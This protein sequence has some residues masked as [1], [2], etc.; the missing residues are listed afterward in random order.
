[1]ESVACFVVGETCFMGLWF[2]SIIGL[3]YEF[4]VGDRGRLGDEIGCRCDRSGIDT[5]ISSGY[6]GDDM[7]LEEKK[8]QN[9][10]RKC[11]YHS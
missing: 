2:L 6:P 10:R 4:L 5:A 7:A 1:M 8:N 3:L 9:D 11:E